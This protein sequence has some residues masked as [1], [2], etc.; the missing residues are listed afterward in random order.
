MKKVDQ[1][2][3]LARIRKFTDTIQSIRAQFAL[4]KADKGRFDTY[5]GALALQKAKAERQTLQGQLD[6]IRLVT[7]GITCR[8]C[9]HFAHLDEPTCWRFGFANPTKVARSNGAE[10]G[11]FAELF[12]NA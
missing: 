12:V 3:L 5:G 1:P 8:D 4:P 6:P 7:R 9:R 11:P 10:C 2:S